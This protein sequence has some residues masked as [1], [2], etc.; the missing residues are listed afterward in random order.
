MPEISDSDFR[1][2]VAYQQIGTPQEITKKV[3][4]LEKDNHQQRDQIRDL[5]EKIPKEG[6]VVLPK[7]KAEALT[8]YEKLGTPQDLGKVSGE[9]D[10]LRKKDQQRTRE[11]A[12]RAAVK[13]AKWPE[14]TVATLLDMRSLDG[15]T[16]EVKKEKSDKGED[17]EV[18]YVTL[19]GDG[20]KAQKLSEFAANAPQ[21]KGLKMETETTTPASNGT[22]Y[23]P[24]TGTPPVRTG[25]VTEED[26]RKAVEKTADYVL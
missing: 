7:E 19:S 23:T 13:A 9:L 11:D 22:R 2:F 15:A 21:L 18:P 4:D 1:Q 16:V 24:Q 14:D 10:D 26:Y 5:K 25:K 8:E 20:Q 17:V 3:G 6:S 12:F